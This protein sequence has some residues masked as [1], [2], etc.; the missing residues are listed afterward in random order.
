MS[1]KGFYNMKTAVILGIGCL[2]CLSACGEKNAVSESSLESVETQSE[3]KQTE[4]ET[5]FEKAESMSET[6]G[7]SQDEMN[8]I[9]SKKI[10]GFFE[11]WKDIYLDGTRA[12]MYQHEDELS[13]SE[14][15]NFSN[16]YYLVDMRLKLDEWRERV[17]DL[18][19]ADYI[20][21]D[22][23]DEEDLK[24]QFQYYIDG[25]NKLYD[26]TI[27]S[28]DNAA[29]KDS[30]I[31]IIARLRQDIDALEQYLDFL[32]QDG[33][34]L[35]SDVV[36]ETEDPYIDKLVIED[37]KLFYGLNGFD[38]FFNAAVTDFN[39]SVNIEYDYT[40]DEGYS[41]YNIFY[42]GEQ[43][44]NGFVVLNGTDSDKNGIHYCTEVYV[45]KADYDVK[46]QP[47]QDIVQSSSLAIV[48]ALHSD[49]TV[50]ECAELF[51]N[52]LSKSYSDGLY[53]DNGTIY[54]VGFPE[55]SYMMKVTFE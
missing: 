46:E 5:V 49:Y 24:N 26:A 52:I 18:N 7:V 15:V 11:E 19:Y 36:E 44:E 39:P 35:E 21:D 48:K 10:N 6:K 45:F 25:Y 43:I 34:S 13:S 33:S 27:K 28:I 54:A 29:V 32:F 53:D 17:N 55:E 37:G 12:F 20:V 8:D 3:I 16:D 41:Y 31:S 9:A 1:K 14:T 40:D 50:S 51:G 38:S 30:G 2:L 22:D 47:M 4:T 42:E 23:I